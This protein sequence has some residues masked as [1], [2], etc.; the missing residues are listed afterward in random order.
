MIFK[1]HVSQIGGKVFLQ[2]FESKPWMIDYFERH[3]LGRKE[4][5][6]WGDEGGNI[7]MAVH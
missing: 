5:G 1:H 7:F 3:F 4:D 2:I 6:R